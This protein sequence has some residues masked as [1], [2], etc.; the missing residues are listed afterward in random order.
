MSWRDS[1]GERRQA[2]TRR[3][4]LLVLVGSVAL[5]LLTVN[6]L[7]IQPSN[8][9][10]VSYLPSFLPSRLGPNHDYYGP[11]YGG[12]PI[13]S[14]DT[15][16]V[17]CAWEDVDEESTRLIREKAAPAFPLLSAWLKPEAGASCSVSKVFWLTSR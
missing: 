1:L 14:N 13:L 5:L 12:E 15:S 11:P 8:P 3:S 6:G 10:R 16:A 2:L 4:R 17:W 9:V 7:H